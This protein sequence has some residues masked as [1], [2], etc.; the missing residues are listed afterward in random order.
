MI[1]GMDDMNSMGSKRGIQM[2]LVLFIYLFIY[3][4]VCLF[5][6]LFIYLF[7]CLF[8]SGEILCYKGWRTNDDKQRNQTA[9]DTRFNVENPLNKRGENHGRQPATIH[10]VGSPVTTPTAAAYKKRMNQCPMENLNRYL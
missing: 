2:D 9:G 8:V 6:Y 3:L 7:V 4:F 10:Y 5:V 1:C